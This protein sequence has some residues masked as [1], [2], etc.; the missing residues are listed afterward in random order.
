MQTRWQSILEVTADLAFSLLINIGGQLVFYPTVATAERV[1]L[2]AVLVLGSACVR[3]FIV[4]R[5]FETFVPAGTRQPHWQSILESGVDTALGFA[6]AVVLQM[7]IYGE[8][9]T[10]LRASGL[11]FLVYG[12]AMFRRYLLRRLFAAWSIRTA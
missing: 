12:F 4:R 1:T 9:A 5:S 2:L 6:I 10:L 3:R 11:T 8:A 7:L